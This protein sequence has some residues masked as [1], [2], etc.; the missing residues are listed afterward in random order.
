MI[1]PAVFKY[2]SLI[3]VPLFGI[4]ALVLI[5]QTKNYSFRTHTISQSVKFLTKSAHN[6]VF[7]LNF[8]IKGILDLFFCLYIL[9]FFNISLYSPI[10]LILILSAVLFVSLG[11]FI[12]SKNTTL[13]LIIVYTS[14]ILWAVGQILLSYRVGNNSF[15]L[16]STIAISLALIIGLASLFLKRTNAYIQAT[17]LLIWYGWL[18]IFVIQYL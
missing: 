18:L 12:E 14:G 3:S 7:R 11:Y 1:F 6:L 5:R 10:S 2:S 13:H 16:F 4:V 15:A 9:N 8:I 17:C